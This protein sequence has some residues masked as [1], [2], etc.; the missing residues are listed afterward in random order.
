MC[1]TGWAFTPALAQVLEDALTVLQTPLS[2]RAIHDLS[3]LPLSCLCAL[4]SYL[5]E[6]MTDSGSVSS[7]EVLNAVAAMDRGPAVHINPRLTVAALDD[8]Q[9]KVR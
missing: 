9:R 2:S 6:V 3:R 8:F 1:F 4:T 7:R 5:C